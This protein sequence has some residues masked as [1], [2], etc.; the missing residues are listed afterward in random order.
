MVTV[1]SIKKIRMII[2]ADKISL[3]KLKKRMKIRLQPIKL[4]KLPRLDAKMLH[5]FAFHIQQKQAISI[6]EST[7]V[8]FIVKNSHEHILYLYNLFVLFKHATPNCRNAYVIQN[9]E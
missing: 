4:S 3:G 5:T 9:R 1:T 2:K 6:V 8:P 7:T